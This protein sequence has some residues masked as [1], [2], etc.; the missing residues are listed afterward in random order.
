MEKSAIEKRIAELEAQN[1]RLQSSIRE[2]SILNDVALA[3][4]STLSLNEII[5]LI[6]QK[7]VK[8]FQVEQAAVW[9][10]KR[11]AQTPAFQTMVRRAD[12]SRFEKPYRLDAQLTGWMLKYRQ[13]LLINDFSGDPRFNH[14]KAADFPVHSVLSVPL[15]VKG[16]LI[17]LISLFNKKDGT[18]F[19]TGDQRLLSIL[20][21]ESAQVI[22]NSRL[23][24]EA[25]E[26]QRLQ[27]EL[28]TAARIQE[29]LLPKQAP[30]IS[31]Y[32]LAAVNL[33][34]RTVSGDYFD[35]IPLGDSRL[36]FCLGDVSGKGMPAALLMANL[37]ATLRSQLLMGLSPA[38]CLRNTNFLL[39]K[40]T[41][42]EKFATLFLGIL[43]FEKHRLTYSNA[44]HD[45]PFWV[46]GAQIKRLQAGGI[47]AGFMESA[48]YEQDA[49]GF[50][51]E[52]VLVLYSDGVTETKNG[53]GEEFGE[54]RLQE[55]IVSLQTGTA[56]EILE[57]I[58]ANVRSFREVQEQS[59]DVTL[60]VVKRERC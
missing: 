53:R 57:G 31:G 2:L 50:A 24:E 59:D 47:V 13:P 10:L 32:D 27:E 52:D 30:E 12:R 23:H 18:G 1:Q 58:L 34:A 8:H 37:Q 44:G 22:E 49:V 17:G 26:L 33:P 35:F 5:D 41:T 14:T 15:M 43:D 11:E 54:E 51:P 21:T 56:A 60:V 55:T 4:R 48:N 39:W 3:I 46:R 25:Q 42:S 9:L 16:E 29:N 36:A 38:D 19:S 28:R 45:A 7:C 6:V 40:N 20:A